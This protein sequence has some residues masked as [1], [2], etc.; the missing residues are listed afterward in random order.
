MTVARR[1]D[2][3]KRKRTAVER[4]LKKRQRDGVVLMKSHVRGNGRDLEDS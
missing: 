4:D 1:A 2:G 3:G